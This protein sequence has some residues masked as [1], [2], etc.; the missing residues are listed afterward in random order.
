METVKIFPC[1]PINEPNVY[2]HFMVFQDSAIIFGELVEDVKYYTMN[3]GLQI[4]DIIK[5]VPGEYI[6]TESGFHN[7]IDSIGSVAIHKLGNTNDVLLIEYLTEPS[8]YQ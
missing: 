4:N 1:N 3:E 8:K 7:G 6:Y 2:L 5:N